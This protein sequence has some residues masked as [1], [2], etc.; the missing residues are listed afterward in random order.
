MLKE[1]KACDHRTYRNY[2]AIKEGHCGCSVQVQEIIAHREAGNVAE[3][4]LQRF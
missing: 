4:R 1:K 3:T 2:L